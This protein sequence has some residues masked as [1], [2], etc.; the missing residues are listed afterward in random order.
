MFL[1]PTGAV[2]TLSFSFFLGT[3]WSYYV[4]SPSHLVHRLTTF[5]PVPPTRSALSLKLG[6]FLE[7]AF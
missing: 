5:L 3:E 7:N 1:I 4:V 6:Y 2:P